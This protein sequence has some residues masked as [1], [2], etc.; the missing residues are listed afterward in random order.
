MKLTDLI[1]RKAIVANVKAN[2]KRGAIKEIV[3]AMK[4]AYSIPRFKPDAIVDAMMER[5]QQSSTGIGG[6]VAV[7]HARVDLVRTAIGA[8]GRSEKGVEYAAVDGEPVH[9][10]FLI[11]SPAARPEEYQRAVKRVMEAIRTPNFARFLRGARTAKDIEDT[12]KE[13]E[14][15]LVKVQ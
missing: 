7:P 12:L 13:T 4:A 10:M 14:D 15:L 5:E 1:A 9:L 2:D 11:L 6:G 8:F 3:T